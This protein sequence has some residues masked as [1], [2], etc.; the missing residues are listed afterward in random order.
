MDFI[1]K[2]ITTHKIH[3]K[4]AR[5]FYSSSIAGLF[6]GVT[7]TMLFDFLTDTSFNRWINLFG[8]EA[9]AAFIYLTFSWGVLFVLYWV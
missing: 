9:F 4:R 5:N 6:S 2:I 1:K 8:L 7:I 3:K